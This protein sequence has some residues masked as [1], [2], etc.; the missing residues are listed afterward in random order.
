MIKTV[1]LVIIL[2]T[3]ACAPKAY[4][5]VVRMGS[6]LPVKPD[7]CSVVFINQAQHIIMQDYTYLGM[8]SVS[9]HSDEMTK[10]S[11][12]IPAFLQESACKLGGDAISLNATASTGVQ[13]VIQIIVWASNS[14]SAPEKQQRDQNTEKDI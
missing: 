8:I 10:L 3:V 12:A 11:S 13:T 1:L 7:N 14:G 6:V 2:I 9:G 5:N 4:V